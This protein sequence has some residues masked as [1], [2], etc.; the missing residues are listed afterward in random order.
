[1]TWSRGA[2]C[3]VP[4]RLERQVKRVSSQGRAYVS[5]L[6][7]QGIRSPARTDRHDGTTTTGVSTRRPANSRT[8]AMPTGHDQEYCVSI[9]NHL[10]A[11]QRT[12]GSVPSLPMPV[13]VATTSAGERA[14]LMA[15]YGPVAAC[16]WYWL[17]GGDGQF[18]D[19][20]PQGAERSDR[21]HGSR[22]VIMAHRSIADMGTRAACVPAPVVFRILPKALVSSLPIPEGAHL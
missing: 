8:P 20:P 4:L 12:S 14:C 10:R 16:R 11:D 9:R 3:G 17:Y 22:S 7:R 2:A 13:L 5:S 21:A 1:M 19:V 6:P 15:S 18:A